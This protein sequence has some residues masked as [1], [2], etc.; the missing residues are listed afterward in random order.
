V[1]IP[2]TPSRRL[3]GL[4]D[5]LGLGAAVAVL[6]AIC[7]GLLLLER[8]VGLPAVIDGSMTPGEIAELLSTA[9]QDLGGERG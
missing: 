1:S 8:A 2:K 4:C 5:G 9:L 6:L 7:G 3:L